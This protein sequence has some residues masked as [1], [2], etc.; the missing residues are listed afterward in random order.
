MKTTSFSAFKPK[1]ARKETRSRPLAHK[2]IMDTSHSPNAFPFPSFR[3][4]SVG[5]SQT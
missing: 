1:A 3:A 2:G 4:P 5:G